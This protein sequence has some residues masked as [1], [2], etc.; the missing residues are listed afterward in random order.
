MMGENNKAL[1]HQESVGER[2]MEEKEKREGEGDWKWGRG[3]FTFFSCL[4]SSTAY[5]HILN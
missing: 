2:K 1:A 5:S 4:Q 3:K